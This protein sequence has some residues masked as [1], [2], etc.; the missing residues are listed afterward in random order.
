VV[1]VA[2]AGNYGGNSRTVYPAAYGGV[3]AVAATDRNNRR[4][5]NSSVGDWV[6]IA[7]PG[8]GILSTKRLARYGTA[9]G[10][11]FSSPFVAGVAGL[12]SAQGRSEGEIRRRMSSTAVDLG[13]AGKDEKYGRGL[14]DAAASVGVRNTKPRIKS[15]RPAPGST[16]RDRTPRIAAVVRDK[17]TDLKRSDLTFVLDGNEKT[18][19]RYDVNRDSLSYTPGR[20]LAPGRHSVKVMVRDG[21]GLKAARRWSF[22]VKPDRNEARSILDKP[23]YPFNILPNN[24]IF[25]RF[26]D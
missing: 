6:D 1:T 12:L 11:S 7:A 26:K 25:D 22:K 3:I 18:S 5:P 20:K 21:Q 16:V 23:G 15:P 24:P 17:E 13:P 2:A 8:A 14:V 9:S 10:T 19:F 4:V